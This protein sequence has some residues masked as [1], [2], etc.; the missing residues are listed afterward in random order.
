M[1]RGGRDIDDQF[2]SSVKGL[3]TDGISRI[4]EILANARTDGDG[5]EIKDE[6]FFS[7]MEISVFIKN[8]IIGKEGLMI[9]IDYLPLMKQ[10]SGIEDVFLFIDK[11]DDGCDG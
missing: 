5:F 8:S 6:I 11:T 1:V 9:G 10:G 7:C 4:P 2:C 3:R